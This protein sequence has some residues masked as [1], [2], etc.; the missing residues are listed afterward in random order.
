MYRT[1]MMDPDYRREPKTNCFCEVCQ[2]DIKATSPKLWIAYE[3]DKLPLIIHPE[4]L[5]EAA[6]DIR[7]RRTTPMT[8]ELQYGRIGT[9]CAKKVGKEWIITK[10]PE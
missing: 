8:R 9:E 7:T 5:D 2:K 3:L 4:D 6:K 1:K 10:G